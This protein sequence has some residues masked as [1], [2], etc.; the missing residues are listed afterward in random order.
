MRLK[1][2]ALSDFL[3]SNSALRIAFFALRFSSEKAG[4]RAR[5][6]SQNR[7][8]CK[9]TWG[10]IN[11]PGRANLPERLK[12][13]AR[14]Q[15]G[16]LSSSRQKHCFCAAKTF[17]RLDRANDTTC[18]VVRLYLIW[19]FLVQTHYK[20]TYKL[21]QLIELCL[22]VRKNLRWLPFSRC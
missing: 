4:R 19:A 5:I 8:K 12:R 13:S 20:V 21:S 18:L 17:A 6:C 10:K 16:A 7:Q 14:R 15:F 2:L 1:T 22:C 11:K 9:Q 3:V